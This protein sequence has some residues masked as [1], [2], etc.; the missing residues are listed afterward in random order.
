VRANLSLTRR[1]WMP[2]RPVRS[3]MVIVP[4]ATRTDGEVAASG[5]LTSLVVDNQLVDLDGTRHELQYHVMALPDGPAREA[6][7]GPLE[8]RVLAV[9]QASRRGAR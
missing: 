5:L 8:R 7:N 3:G 1:I 4:T 9:A 6:V 2:S